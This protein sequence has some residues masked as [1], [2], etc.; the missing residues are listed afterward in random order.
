MNDNGKK[1]GGGFRLIDWKRLALENF[2]YECITT[3]GNDFDI[4]DAFGV[5]AIRDTYNRAFNEWKGEY[6]YLTELVMILNWK[7]HQYHGENDNYARLYNELWEAADGYACD[8]LTGEE[9]DYFY[10]TTN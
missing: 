7:I 4:A 5:D 3:F 1:N 6:K 8:N 10:R 2:G 9:A